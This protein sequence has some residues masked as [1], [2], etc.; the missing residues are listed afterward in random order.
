[1]TIRMEDLGPVAYGGGVALAEW[2]DE[3]RITEGK[4]TE[5]DTWKKAS[6]WT[7]LGLGGAATLMSAFNFMPRYRAWA[8]PISH[9]F[10][11]DFPRFVRR[12]VKE[13]GTTAGRGAGSRAISE[14]NQILAQRRQ[15][16]MGRVAD[17]SYQPEFESVAPHAF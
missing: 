4:L 11:Y 5:K 9:G 6:T 1:M 7:Y 12:T 15:L 13:M 16:A 10:M 14:A 17:R 3:K 8:E 2:Y